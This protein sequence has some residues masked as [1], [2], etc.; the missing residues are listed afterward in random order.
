MGLGT[1][2]IGKEWVA[3]GPADEPFKFP[4]EAAPDA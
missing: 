2:K 4:E 3:Y 1:C